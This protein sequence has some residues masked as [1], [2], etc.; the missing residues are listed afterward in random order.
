MS[1]G[2]L[3]RSTPAPKNSLVSSMTVSCS[4]AS[5][6]PSAAAQILKDESSKQPIKAV[7]C[8]ARHMTYTSPNRFAKK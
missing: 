2:V 6:S 5:S 1:R 3:R 4:Q 7:M 8:M